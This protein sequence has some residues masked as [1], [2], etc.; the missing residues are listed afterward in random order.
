MQ[1]KVG[2]PC[3]S[4]QH[5]PKPGSKYKIKNLR[6]F[7]STTQKKTQEQEM[8]MYNLLCMLNRNEEETEAEQRLMSQRRTYMKHKGAALIVYKNYI[9]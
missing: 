2:T 8:M 3:K 7:L 5:N 6:K 9:V 1:Q 4:E